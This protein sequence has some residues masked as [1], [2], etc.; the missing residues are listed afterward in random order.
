MS[1]QH[2]RTHPLPISKR[3]V[4][5]SIVAAF[6][7]LLLV[8]VWR[9]VPITAQT[10]SAVRQAEQQADPQPM[11]GAKCQKC[12]KE[13]VQ[14]FARDVHGKSA[15]FLKDARAATCESCHG[16]GAK[17]IESLEAKDIINPPKL[18]TAGANESCLQCHHRDTTYQT[19]RGGPHERNDMSCLSCHSAHDAKS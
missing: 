11:V 14:S 13:V 10:E 8:S 3:V 2:D 9:A 16:D 15:K 5:L 4:A 1:Q 6:A 12:H 18:T 19:W 7:C 17:H